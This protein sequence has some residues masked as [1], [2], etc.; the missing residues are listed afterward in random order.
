MRRDDDR[1][2]LS[3]RR[4]DAIDGAVN[5]V[6]IAFRVYAAVNQNMF[7]CIAAGLIRYWQRHEKAIAETDPIHTYANGISA[8]FGRR[9]SF[10]ACLLCHHRQYPL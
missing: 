3:G 8:E 6:Q 4:A 10:R 5:H 1:Q 2:L 9:H 7:V